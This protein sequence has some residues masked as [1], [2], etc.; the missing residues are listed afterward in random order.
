[1]QY[2]DTKFLTSGCKLMDYPVTDL[3]EIIF[4]GRSNSGKSS[5]INS[6][7]GRKNLAYSGKTPGKTKLLNF[8]EIDHKYIYCDAPGYGYASGGDKAAIDFG[9]LMETYFSRRENL[10][11]MV[12]VLDSRRIPNVDDIHMVEYARHSHIAIIGACTKIDKLS[13]NELF[14]SLKK[15]SKTLGIPKESLYPCSNLN[16]KGIDQILERIDE[17]SYRQN[18]E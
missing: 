16:R 6:L 14:N 18:N 1:M 5:L 10:K 11:A 3:P 4:T 7:T 2:H 13:N 12:I 17:I 8:F 15:I 9:Y